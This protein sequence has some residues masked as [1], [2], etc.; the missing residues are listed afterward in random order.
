MIVRPG[1]TLHED[2]VQCR[3]GLLPRATSPFPEASHVQSHTRTAEAGRK[4]QLV[5]R[6]VPNRD[7]ERRRFS[8]CDPPISSSMRVPMIGRCG[9]RR[10]VRSIPSVPVS[11]SPPAPALSRS[12]LE[13][14]TVRS[15]GTCCCAQVS[16][17]RPG[18]GRSFSTTCVTLAPWRT[19]LLRSTATV[20]SPTRYGPTLYTS[21]RGA[22]FIARAIVLVPDI[23]V[24]LIQQTRRGMVT[25]RGTPDSIAAEAFAVSTALSVCR[26]LDILNY[27]VLSD[28]QG[29]VHKFRHE[30]VEW[31]SREPDASAKRLLRQGAPACRVPSGIAREG[32]Q[33]SITPDPSARGV[34]TVQCF[35]SHVHPLSQPTVVAGAERRRSTSRD[36]RIVS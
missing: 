29:A 22:D 34:R 20:L 4:P 33:S 17:G 3:A 9:T 26:K 19:G 32:H 1:R 6:E 7:T 36:A 30:R 24:G 25:E 8:D 10:R 31:R 23:D 18:R 35:K 12:S 11:P 15:C 13:Q 14:G 28:C 2:R 16:R 5:V 21:A 27:V